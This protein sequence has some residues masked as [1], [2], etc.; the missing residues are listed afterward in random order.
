M[1]RQNIN[2]GSA[3]NDGTG[4]TLRIA[5]QKINQNFAEIYE[6]LSGDS[7]QPSSNIQIQDTTIRR[8]QTATRYTD[9]A[10]TTPTAARTITFPN[11]TGTVVLNN[12]TDTLTNKTLTAPVVS[13]LNVKD[14]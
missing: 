10:F 14:D 5:G 1:A 4:D 3:A 12:T 2:I 13:S 7:G 9:L 11:A 8:L 6:Q